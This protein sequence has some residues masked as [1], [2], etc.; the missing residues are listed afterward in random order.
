MRC[1]PG[2]GNNRNQR[3]SLVALGVVVILFV[4]GWILAHELYSGEKL[5]DC[6]MSGRSNCAPLDTQSH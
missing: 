5:E 6:L 4:V 1:M 3:G 2:S